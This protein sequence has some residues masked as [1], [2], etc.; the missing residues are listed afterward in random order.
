MPAVAV[1]CPRMDGFVAPVEELRRAGDAAG[2]VGVAV[3]SVELASAARTLSA[4]LPGG[5][6]AQAAA[7]I[8]RRW[9]GL[10]TSAADL[11]QAQANGLNSTAENYLSTDGR[12]ARGL[13]VR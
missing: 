12:A 4:A 11:M 7:E 8:E 1:T 5:A 13:A 9:A 10:V 6:V 2:R 3:R